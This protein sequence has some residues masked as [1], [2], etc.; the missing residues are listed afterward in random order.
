MSAGDQLLSDL[1]AIALDLAAVDRMTVE[2]AAQE[3]ENLRRMISDLEDGRRA[4]L[5]KTRSHALDL[6]T[7]AEAAVKTL[8]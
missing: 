6:L 4:I 7:V 1:R 2:L 8:T 3:I 5:P